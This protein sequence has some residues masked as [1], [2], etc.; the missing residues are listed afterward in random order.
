[1]NKYLNELYSKY[2]KPLENA[3]KKG[4]VIQITDTSSDF[5]GQLAVVDEPRDWGVVA[6]TVFN[7]EEYRFRLKKGSYETVGMAVIMPFSS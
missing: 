7:R 6:I 1:M 3:P 5:F 2:T 4:E